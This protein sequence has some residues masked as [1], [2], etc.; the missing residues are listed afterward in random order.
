MKIEKGD[1]IEEGVNKI[2]FTSMGIKKISLHNLKE[3]Q[4]FCLRE[5]DNDYG[6][7]IA[8]LL[9]FYNTGITTWLMDH[10][11]RLR[12]LE[13]K[14]EEDKPKRKVPNTFGPGDKK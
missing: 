2:T 11:Q 9:D 14:P 10:E 7:G 5:C 6:K 8:L 3:F 4:R 12:I 1:T 13:G